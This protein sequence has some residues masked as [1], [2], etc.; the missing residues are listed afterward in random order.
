MSP[1]GQSESQRHC[2][3]NAGV[4]AVPEQVWPAQVQPGFVA[5]EVHQPGSFAPP[6]GSAAGTQT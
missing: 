4:Q 5:V 1:E 6:S 2:R 3:W